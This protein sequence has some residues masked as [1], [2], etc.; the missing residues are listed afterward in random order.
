MKD[1]GWLRTPPRSEK[2]AISDLRSYAKKG[3]HRDL[4]KRNIDWLAKR[5]RDYRYYFQSP[6]P[7]LAIK[8]G[9]NEE[10]K[11]VLYNLYTSTRFRGIDNFR[12]LSS[13]DSCPYCGLRN[14]VTLDHYLPRRIQDFP[15]LSYFS[16][17][18]V[19]SCSDCQF[20]KSTFV[21]ATLAIRNLRG[22]KRFGSKQML[23]R[24]ASTQLGHRSRSRITNCNRM[25]HPYFDRQVKVD[26][27]LINF[28]FD[29]TVGP[30]NFRVALKGSHRSSEG[31]LI[32]FH[33]NKLEMAERLVHP[34]RRE[35]DS[36][37]PYLNVALNG[38]IPE[39]SNVKQLLKAQSA[40][41][42]SKLG[43]FSMEAKF[44]ESVANNKDCI[45]L[46]IQKIAPPKRNVPKNRRHGSPV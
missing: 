44:L 41:A 3:F 19:P 6:L 22:K 11:I 4:I 18:L 35:W 2:A 38:K 37:I 23:P 21:P 24:P 28:D 25:I 45:A 8:D 36:L 10:E 29:T 32:S 31:R 34:L 33:F 30:I 12:N 42:K 26:E 14:P 1:A 17:N 9:L 16:L 46:L 20:K 43:L 7:S 5:C 13:W 40:K 39:S 15:H 27:I